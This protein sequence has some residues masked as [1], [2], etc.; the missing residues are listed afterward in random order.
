MMHSDA[1][2]LLANASVEHFDLMS[3]FPEVL[4]TSS[5]LAWSGVTQQDLFGFKLKV[6]PGRIPF[7]L[8]PAS[9]A[10]ACPSNPTPAS[11]AHAFPLNPAAHAFPVNHESNAHMILLENIG[12]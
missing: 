2:S 6:H 10:H 5:S 3:I 7:Y 8:A 12:L 11:N 1:F 9:H 4:Q